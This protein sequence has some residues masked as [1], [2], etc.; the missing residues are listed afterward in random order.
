M[1]VAK[2]G[3]KLA[4]L[5]LDATLGDLPNTDF[6][7][8]GEA[9]GETVEHVFLSRSDLPG[10]LI[11]ETDRAI[12]MLSRRRFMEILSQPFRRDLYLK[13]PIRVM[14]QN[15][16][17]SLFILEERERIN[18][19]VEKAL[20][21]PPDEAYEPIAVSVNGKNLCLLSVDLLLRAQ[22]Q[23]LALANEEK[24]RLLE[25][26]RFSEQ[27]LR[28]TLEQ[29][30]HT[31]DQLIQSKKMAALGQLV[32]G[33]AHEINTPIGIAL[34][35]ISYLAEQTSEFDATYG[36][37]QMKKSTLEGYI[38]TAQ[39]SVQLVR[40][41]IQRAAVLISSFKQ[42]AVDQTSEI[43]RH[44]QMR[45]FLTELLSSLNPE[46]RRSRH[47]ILLECPEQIEMNS[48]PGA[49]A[50]VVT[51]LV[52][53]ALKHA[54][55]EDQNGTLRIEVVPKDAEVTL[56][57]TD[58]GQGIPD[59]ILPRI[60][61][62]FF[63]T[64]RSSGGTGLG[65]HIVYNLIQERLKGRIAVESIVGEGTRFTVTIPRLLSQSEGT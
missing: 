13:R 8:G 16:S 65:L 44:F 35:A 56:A 27:N 19:A 15:G 1:V 58:D 20:S 60:F 41:N 11:Y 39:Q 22:S 47:S 64:K 24:G 36:Q 57:V 18:S 52:G 29:L 61:D 53:N 4:N 3:A 59:D 21:R 23:I 7:V 42:V 62:P 14:L 2:F 37:G 10:V 9:S 26:I 6:R 34:T 51:N 17:S 63:T 12:G 50:Q 5:T 46:F 33:V 25:E 43:Q 45:E 49:L 54:F 55:D 30:E 40:N 38:T 28:K 32:A 48:F 31:Q